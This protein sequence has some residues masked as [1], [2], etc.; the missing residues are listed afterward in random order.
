MQISVLL[1]YAKYIVHTLTVIQVS[2][3]QESNQNEQHF[4]FST[5]IL[6]NFIAVCLL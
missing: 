2:Y 4:A 3:Q 6:T 5:E 1:N